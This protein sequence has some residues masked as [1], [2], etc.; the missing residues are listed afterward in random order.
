[1]AVVLFCTFMCDFTLKLQ[2]PMSTNDYLWVPFVCQSQVLQVQ[3]FLM[4]AKLE[5]GEERQRRDRG[6][7]EE[8]GRRE[9]GERE[10]DDVLVL[11]FQNVALCHSF[12]LALYNSAI[13]PAAPLNTTYTAC[14]YGSAHRGIAL[15]RIRGGSNVNRWHLGLRPDLQDH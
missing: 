9:G 12:R 10:G 7:R 6:E 1:M 8:R 13:L 2:L 14:L 11:L 4:A 15:C 3:H 5:R